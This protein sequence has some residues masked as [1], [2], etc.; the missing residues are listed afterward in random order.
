MVSG[1]GEWSRFDSSVEAVPGRCYYEPSA[2][3]RLTGSPPAA[4]DTAT[5]ILSLHPRA[6]PGSLLYRLAIPATAIPPPRY[7]GQLAGTEH[8]GST[9]F[10]VQTHPSCTSVTPDR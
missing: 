9:Y 10:N 6:I 3:L 8:T 2:G 1:A 4:L 5:A 7:T